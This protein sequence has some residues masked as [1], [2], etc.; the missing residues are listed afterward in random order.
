MCRTANG[1]GVVPVVPGGGAAPV[2]W[3]RL[4]MYVRLTACWTQ[5]WTRDAGRLLQSA[6]VRHRTALARTEM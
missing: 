6:A 1:D 2:G 5:L 4:H 3:R